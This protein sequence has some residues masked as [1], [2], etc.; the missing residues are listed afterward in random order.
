MS[1]TNEYTIP[2]SWQM[3]GHLK[4]Q[5]DSLEDAIEIAE[6]DSTNLP[7]GSYVEASFEVDHD[8]LED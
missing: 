7:D 1:T 8:V 6:S 4:I 5:A 3:Y 2:C